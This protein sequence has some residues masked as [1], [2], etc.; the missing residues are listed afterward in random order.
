MLCCQ[1]KIDSEVTHPNHYDLIGIDEFGLSQT[2]VAMVIDGECWKWRQLACF[3]A[4]SC[5][6]V[7]DFS[8]FWAKLRLSPAMGVVGCGVITD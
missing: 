8:L 5:A 2:V 4:E 1:T 7:N 3:N 6:V